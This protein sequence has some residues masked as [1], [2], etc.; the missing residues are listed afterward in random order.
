MTGNENK[1]PFLYE[2]RHAKWPQIA[3]VIV[4]EGWVRPYF[5]IIPS[6]A[7]KKNILVSGFGQIFYFRVGRSGEKFFLFKKFFFILLF[8]WKT[9][10][11]NDFWM[12]NE[13]KKF[14]LGRPLF[15]G[16][17]GKPET[18]IFVQNFF[19]SFVSMRELH[20]NDFWM[21]KVKKFFFCK[22]FGSAP[23]WRVGRETGDVN[24]FGP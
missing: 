9:L 7:E 13:K 14:F 8:P 18:W 2:R 5:G 15:Q 11:K 20:K 1:L 10:F 17:V 12:K 22:V 6:K 23:F 3:T 4:K 24:F 19:C 16:S 21:E